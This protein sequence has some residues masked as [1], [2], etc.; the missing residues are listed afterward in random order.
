MDVIQV[1]NRIIHLSFQ[2]RGGA[3][4]VVGAY[5]PHSVRDFEADRQPFWET[6]DEHLSRIPHPEPGDFNVRFQASHRSDEGVTGPH[7]YGKG[8]RFIDHTA[9]SNRALCI[10]TMQSLGMVEAASYITPMPVHHITYRDKAAPPASWEQFIM[11]PLILQQL[12]SKFQNLLHESSLEIS[13]LARSFLDLPELLPPTKNQP[14]PDPVR[15]QRL[16]HTFVRAQWLHSVSSCR[17]K[18]HAGFPSDHYPLV[19]EV[20][21]KLAAKS[22]RKPPRRRFDFSQVTPELKAQFNVS[23]KY[24]LGLQNVAE[25]EGSLSPDHTAECT[26]YTDGSGSKG[27]C[28][29]STPAGWGVVRGKDRGRR[30]ARLDRR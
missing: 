20:Q 6:L 3:V 10:K 27:R 17:S 24:N 15:F 5:D 25:D 21:V 29:P 13:A 9:T 23:L 22:T 28:G 30:R 2:K 12:Y 8:T 1:N 18:L 19:T 7:T 16:D 4:H 26:F 14:N 11:D